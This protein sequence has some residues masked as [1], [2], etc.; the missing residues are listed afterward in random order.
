MG[1]WRLVRISRR[2]GVEACSM[3]P[4][5]RRLFLPA[6]RV[7]DAARF[8]GARAGT[9]SSWHHRV[10]PRG[11]VL[12][13]RRKGQ[14]LSYYELI[15]VAFVATLRGAGVPMQRIRRARQY[16]AQALN[17]EYPFAQFEWYGQGQHL[18]FNLREID[19]D[20]SL[21]KLVVADKYGQVTWKKVMVDRFEEFEYENQIALKWFVGGRDS[22]VV[23]DP[24]V[25]FGAPT[26]KGIPTWVLKG[27]WVAGETL[28][29]IV[30]DFSLDEEVVVKG[31]QFEGIRVAA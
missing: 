25:S 29:E 15:E 26:V 11:P 21:D 4:W 20:A 24:R 14:H 10:G 5:H 13:T 2:D 28:N 7:S 19:K 27:R 8:S 3:E 6:Y 9:I 16:A 17:C 23:I 22:S 31:L 12:P 1:Y 30:E 18:M